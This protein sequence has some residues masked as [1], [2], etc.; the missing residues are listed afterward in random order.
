M[1]VFHFFTACRHHHTQEFKEFWKEHRLEDFA[2]LTD[3]STY[4][5]D[6]KRAANEWVQTYYELEGKR[7]KEFHELWETRYGDG[8][9]E[10]LEEEW[11]YKEYDLK[12]FTYTEDLITPRICTCCIVSTEIA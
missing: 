8:T 2:G 1:D 11:V 3:A 6:P 9:T 10:D 5:D 7:G 4:Y 12:E